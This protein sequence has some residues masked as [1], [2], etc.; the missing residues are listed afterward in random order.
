MKTRQ[1]GPI[2][3]DGAEGGGQLL[4]TALSLS[5]LTGTPFRIE[6]IRGGRS[7][8]GM[9][10]QHLT[11]VQAA[12]AVCGATVEGAV[13]GSL[14]L[15][16]RPGPIR[17]GDYRFAIGSAGS[18]ILVLQTVLPALWFADG[19]A[20]VTVSGGTHNQAA[21]PADFLI[22]SWQ[23]LLARMGVRQRLELR[24]HG[25]YPAG[26]G[27][28]LATVEPCA[29]LTPLELPGRG[30]LRRLRAEA[31]VAG[32]PAGIAWRELQRVRQLLADADIQPR[33]LPREQGPGNV[34]M[35]EV[36]GDAVCEL[37]TGFGAKGVSAESVAERT[38]AEVERYLHSGA[39]VGEHLADQLLLPLALAGGG[40]FTTTHV[41]DHLHSNAAVIERFLAVEVRFEPQE[42]RVLV[43]VRPS[44]LFG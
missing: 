25:F 31:L 39:A 35:I 1:T 28:L 24:R 32:L 30:E 27:E 40:A 41:S 38:V 33:E 37:F 26:G 5:M 17:G 12:A 29:G 14:A 36:A 23:P 2:V 7:R 34:L 10:R 19:P 21:P 3:L 4:R 9:L 44:G 18:C 13:L 15:S 8:P 20:T 16:F 22:R 6:R 42:T 11:A 43:R